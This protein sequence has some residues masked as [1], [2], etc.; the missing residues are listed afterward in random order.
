ML[1]R[2]V[3]EQ[4]QKVY[5]NMLGEVYDDPF[6]GME[7][8]FGME[9]Y[10]FDLDERKEE[11]EKLEEVEDNVEQMV[12]DDLEKKKKEELLSKIKSFGLPT[13]P[14]DNL[15]GPAKAAKEANKIEDNANLEILKNTASTPDSKGE[16]NLEDDGGQAVA[17]NFN[18]TISLGEAANA[19]GRDVK[20][21]LKK[22]K[23]V[24]PLIK[25]RRKKTSK[26]KKTQEL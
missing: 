2:V 7:Q 8:V 11:D 3:I 19:S 24:N 6:E 23:V 4:E 16:V 12:K 9:E 18:V 14:V 22:T 1:F 21:K 13:A 20:Q 25:K 26:A 5:Q 15:L 10:M 17:N